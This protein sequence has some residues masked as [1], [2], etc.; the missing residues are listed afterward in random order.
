[1]RIIQ[2]N[3]RHA[4]I[5]TTGNSGNMVLENL[6][7]LDHLAGFHPAQAIMQCNPA[8]GNC[9]STSAAIGLYNIAVDGDLIFTQ[10]LHIDN[11]AQGT[12]DQTLTF[13]YATTLFAAGGFTA[14]TVTG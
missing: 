2:I 4:F 3:H 11:S 12:A 5:N 7:D 10:S 14:H 8:A 13:L 9:R 6:D 1:F